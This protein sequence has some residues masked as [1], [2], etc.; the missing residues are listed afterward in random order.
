MNTTEIFTSELPVGEKL[1]IRRTRFEPQEKSKN[2]VTII[3]NIDRK[4]SLDIIAKSLGMGM[5]DLLSEIEAIVNSGTKINIDYYIDDVM[6]DDYQND[7][8]D[9]FREESKEGSIEE[10]VKDLG[11]NDY[12]VEDIRMVRI[13][14][15]SEMGN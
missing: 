13:K 7:I 6:D 11:E 9:Y 8:Y 14:F 4:V 10:A 3:Q 2:K 12:S 1:S 5:E 15:I